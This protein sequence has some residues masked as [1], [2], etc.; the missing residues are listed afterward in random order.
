MIEKTNY[1]CEKCHKTLDEKQFY[2]SNN[3]EK[4]PPDGHLKLCK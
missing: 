2:K 1:F 4:Y 3:I